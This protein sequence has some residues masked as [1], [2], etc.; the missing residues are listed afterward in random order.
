MIGYLSGYSDAG[1]DPGTFPAFRKGLKETGFVEGRNINIEFRFAGGRYDRLPSLAA[2]LV[3]RKV[4]VILAAG[5]PSA[6]AAKAATKTIPVVFAIGVDPVK[7]GLVE[8]L[9]R[10]NGNLTGVSIFS[11]DLGPK[12]VELLHELLPAVSVIALLGNLKNANLQ[13]AVPDIRAATD[14][15][16]Q[17]LEVLTASTESE[18][19]A[20]FATMAQNRVGGLV[21]MAD[22]FLISRRDKLVELAGLHAIPAI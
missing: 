5:V 11:A 21:V 16:R 13:S 7:V 2:E 19:D 8:S 22:P 14:A 3:A 1:R 17:R 15:L 12:H 18:L 9:S 4:S 10:P 20:A 6:L